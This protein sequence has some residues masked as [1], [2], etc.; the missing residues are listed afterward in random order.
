MRTYKP[1]NQDA[2]LTHL[3]GKVRNYLVTLQLETLVDEAVSLFPHHLPLVPRLPSIPTE[4]QEE[5]EEQALVYTMET[6]WE[7]NNK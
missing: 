4:M 5:E 1:I 6:P 3:Q 2:A 7:E